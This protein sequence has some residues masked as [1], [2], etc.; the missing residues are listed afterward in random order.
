MEI[1]C[2]WKVDVEELKSKIEISEEMKLNLEKSLLIPSDNDTKFEI[3]M[4][5]DELVFTDLII[6]SS[7]KNIELYINGEYLQ[8]ISATKNDNGL[9]LVEFHKPQTCQKL[10]FKFLS[11]KNKKE[12]EISKIYIRGVIKTH[13]EEEFDIDPKIKKYIDYKFE[14]LLYK[15]KNNKI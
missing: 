1:T 2:T 9:F 8:T 13:K 15:L 11:L 6:L 5:F 12:I 10:L 14:E 3:Q 4:N 7:S